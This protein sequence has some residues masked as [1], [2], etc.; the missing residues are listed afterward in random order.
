[1]Q[2]EKVIYTKIRAVLKSREMGIYTE[3]QTLTRIEKIIESRVAELTAAMLNE[4]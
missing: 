2:K 3:M 4:D 1:M